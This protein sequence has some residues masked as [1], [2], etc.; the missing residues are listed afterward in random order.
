MLPCL[1]QTQPKRSNILYGGGVKWLGPMNQAP[2]ATIGSNGTPI[3]ISDK[4]RC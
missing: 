1:A 3:L 4:N 2:I